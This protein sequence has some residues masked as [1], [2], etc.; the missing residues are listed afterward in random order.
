MLDLLQRTVRNLTLM[1]NRIGFDIRDVDSCVDRL[2]ADPALQTE[3][4]ILLREIHFRLSGLILEL[5]RL[6]HADESILNGLDALQTWIH[7]TEL[8][9][10]QMRGLFP[11]PSEDHKAA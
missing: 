7:G 8:K 9:M 2:E 5:H 1:V 11:G 6:R 4:E 3:L 10:D